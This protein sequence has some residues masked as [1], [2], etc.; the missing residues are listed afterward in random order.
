[1]SLTSII[2]VSFKS[3]A[4][5]FL[6][7]FLITSCQK[8]GEP[9][10]VFNNS[11]TQANSTSQKSENDAGINNNDANEDSESTIVGGG[12]NDS[13]DDSDGTIVGGGSN[14]SDDDSDGLILDDGN[15]G[16]ITDGDGAGL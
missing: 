12:S 4:L 1:M 14:D 15:S 11:G 8:G 16:I 6:V 3:I 2:T 9:V 5:L 13:D 10:P 7:T